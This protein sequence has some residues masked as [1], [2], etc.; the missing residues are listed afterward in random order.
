M[1]RIGK[2]GETNEN[3]GF[4]VGAR[5]CWGNDCDVILSF[6]WSDKNVLKLIVLIVAQP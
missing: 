5:G 2:A 1:S 4:C 3:D 6:I